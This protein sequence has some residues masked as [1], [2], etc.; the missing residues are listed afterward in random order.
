MDLEDTLYPIDLFQWKNPVIIAFS[1]SGETE[2]LLEAVNQFKQ[3][4]CCVLS[5]TNSPR[6]T[7]A[8]I[9]DWNFAYNLTSKRVNGGYNGTT[10]VPVLFIMEALAKRI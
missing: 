7:L 10:Q 3:K 5:V 8:K 4:D 1:E 2:S 6:S 9:S